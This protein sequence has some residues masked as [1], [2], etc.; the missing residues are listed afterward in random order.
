LGHR[1]FPVYL[2]RGDRLSAL[3]EAGV[4]AAADDVC[5]R[6]GQSGTAPDFIVITHP[7]GDHVAGLDAIRGRFPA[8]R[9]LAGEG[10]A[11]FLAQPRIA[12][13]IEIEDLSLSSRLAA[14]GYAGPSE[15]G[16]RPSLDGAVTCRDGEEIDL[17]GVTLRLLAVGGHAP[18]NLAVFI[19]EERTL[20]ASDSL[21]FY[22]PG[23]R[24]F[25]VFFTGFSAYMAALERLESLNPERLG[26]GHYGWMEGAEVGEA[27]ALARRCASVVRGRLKADP[28][29][30]RT[31]VST[32]FNEFYRDELTLYSRE[33]IR[34]CCR[35][36][37]RRS[38]EEGG[39]W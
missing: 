10:A 35:L 27:F 20:L 24:F 22:Y 8:L 29:D 26:L 38:R 16:K 25:P 7:H 33:N 17:G 28:S 11:A 31:A 1:A 36:L 6:L 21:G 9:V 5:R 13:A 37:L 34:E 12:E 15:P 39:R 32:I 18:G 30:D 4:S 14:E 2:V 23:G 3:V 19:P